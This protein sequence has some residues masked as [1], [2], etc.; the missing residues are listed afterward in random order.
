IANYLKC[1]SDF[2]IANKVN[3]EELYFAKFQVKRNS[4]IFAE[5][6]GIIKRDEFGKRIKNTLTFGNV[7]P[8]EGK[9]KNLSAPNS[10]FI[11]KWCNLFG[12]KLKVYDYDFL[13]PNYLK[14]FVVKERKKN[15]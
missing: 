5:N 8:L 4:Y 11:A 2:F 13:E 6:L 10:S 9:I 14:N 15:D 12:E 3:V 7:F 1:D